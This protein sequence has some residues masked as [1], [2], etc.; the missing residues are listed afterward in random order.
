MKTAT[1]KTI[2][3]VLVNLKCLGYP[4]KCLRPFSKSEKNRV[5]DELAGRGW[6]D[7]HCQPTLAAQP[8]ILAN[9]NLCQQ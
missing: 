8:V 3:T 9:L 1:E 6:I 7:E 4:G 2:L 5:F